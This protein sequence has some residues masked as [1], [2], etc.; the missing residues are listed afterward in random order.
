[1][2]WFE[3]LIN[4]VLQILRPLAPLLSSPLL[5]VLPFLWFLLNRANTP[6]G[7][8]SAI[9]ADR[10]KVQVS[11]WLLLVVTYYNMVGMLNASVY[12][13]AL[14]AIMAINIDRLVYFLRANTYTN[15]NLNQSLEHTATL[16]AYYSELDILEQELPN[17]NIN[18]ISATRIRAAL[19]SCRAY[20]EHYPEAD[21]GWV[22]NKLAEA[23]SLLNLPSAEEIALLRAFFF[24]AAAL[25]F[26]VF[27]FVAAGYAFDPLFLS[28]VLSV[29]FFGVPA[30]LIV[31]S[32]V[33]SIASLLHEYVSKN[34]RVLGNARSL[35]FE[36]IL[37]VVLSS[38]SYFALTAV[39]PGLLADIGGE[40]GVA[41]LGID[42]LTQQRGQFAVLSVFGFL[43]GFYEEISYTFL[44]E[45]KNRLDLTRKK[46][47]S[48]DADITQT[49]EEDDPQGATNMPAAVADTQAPPASVRNASDVNASGINAD[50]ANEIAHEVEPSSMPSSGVVPAQ[51]RQP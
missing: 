16:P 27:Q 47:T 28:T 43:T 35:F 17:C 25:T 30:V 6:A 3:V 5:L 21:L 10:L 48:E 31:W 50:A 41:G 38:V 19:D 26:V 2:T 36:P 11:M 34:G 23:R 46:Q 9:S 44:L 22:R 42:S 33:G 45:A 32:A 4:A 15:T 7:T 49:S 29:E 37:S 12:I 40:I 13:S 20:L 51:R 14:L 24:F 18:K 39:F 8:A 1:M